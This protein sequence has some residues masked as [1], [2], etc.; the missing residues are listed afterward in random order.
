MSQGWANHSAMCGTYSCRE[1]VQQ[2]ATYSCLQLEQRLLAL[3]GQINA[4]VGS[5]VDTRATCC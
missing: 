5:W 1:E 4:I 3:C 2:N